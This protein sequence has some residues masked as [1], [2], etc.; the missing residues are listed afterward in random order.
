MIP[1]YHFLLIA[2]LF[3]NLAFCSCS[4]PCLSRMS[5]GT[6]ISCRRVVE[7]DYISNCLGNSRSRLFVTYGV[8]ESKNYFLHRQSFG[9]KKLSWYKSRRTMQPFL[10]ASAEDG[11]A[12]NGSSQSRASDDVEEMRSKLTGSLHDEY[13]CDELIQ[14]LHD[15]ARTF[16]LALKKKISSSKLPWFSAAWLGVDRNAWVKTFSYQVCTILVP[17][18]YLPSM[19]LSGYRSWFVCTPMVL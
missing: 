9:N 12:V 3:I 1:F 14:S 13:N 17:L 2:F 19:H 8:L 6:F 16:E 5:I 10:L 4:N 11:V 7:F 18:L 15:A